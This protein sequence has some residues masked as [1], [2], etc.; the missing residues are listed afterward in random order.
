MDD[1]KIT[2]IEQQPDVEEEA[3]ESYSQ[4]D[5]PFD[6]MGFD[7]NIPRKALLET[8]EAWQ[9]LIERMSRE[10]GRDQRA[11]ALVAQTRL[12]CGVASCVLQ[13]WEA[14]ER[15]LEQVRETEGTHPSIV[16][17]ATW[18]LSTVYAGQGQYARAIDCWSAILAE[19]EAAGATKRRSLPE[20]MR[21]LYLYRAELYAEL[22]KYAE[23]HAD[24]NRALVSY[25][26]WAE[27]YSVRGLCRARLGDMESALAD[28]ARSIELEPSTARCYRRRG[29][30][31]TL[32]K[33]YV[34]AVADFDR[35]LELDP[36]DELAQQ[37][38]IR[39]VGGYLFHD[40]LGGGVARAEPEQAALSEVEQGQPGEPVAEG[41][42]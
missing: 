38:R 4:G 34:A 41:V 1:Q 18:L 36:T 20:Q 35:A 10:A 9:G 23:A 40:L 11:A 15:V 30:V 7:M 17:S 13:D 12:R 33:D 3:R 8:I 21:R 14:A 5:E 39:A 25:P 32:R 16:R 22:E 24:C 19:C 31:L 37:G 26:E 27:V 29:V 28:C 2:E 42:N 6:F